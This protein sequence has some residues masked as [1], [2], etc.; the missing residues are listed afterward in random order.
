[1]RAEARALAASAA[2]GATLGALAYTAFA[3]SRVRAFARRPR[4]PATRVPRVSVLK[5]LHG[6]EALL[7]QK[8][9]SFCDQDYPDFEV[10]LGARDPADPALTTARALAAE[11]PGRVRVVVADAA[12]P[13]H[14]NPKADTLAALVPHADGELLAIVDS[15]MRVGPDWLLAV[16]A[17]FDDAQV[18][19]TTCLYRGEALPGLASALGAMANHEHFA[20][21]VLVAQALGPLRYTFGSTMAVRRT[22]FEQ[23]GGLDAI[24]AHLADD[25]MLG[26]LVARAGLRIELSTYVVGNVVDEP[27]LAALWQHELRWARTHRLLR[28]AG[29]AGLFLTYP[30]PLA[31]LYLALARRRGPALVLLATAAALRFALAGAARRAFGAGGPTRPWLVPLRDALGLAVWAAAYAGRGVRWRG[32]RHRT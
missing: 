26:E 31:L 6:D 4:R 11:F 23:I 7:A 25:A 9:R 22:T 21:S 5:P 15:D 13:H 16:V 27:S 28:P 18:G 8:L 10:I 29:Y 2:L 17:P 24:G 32:E 19:A 3:L 14:R 30:L 1:V 12:T 20:P